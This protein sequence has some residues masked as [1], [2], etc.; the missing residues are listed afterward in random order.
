MSPLTRVDAFYILVTGHLLDFNAAYKLIQLA[1]LLRV[2]IPCPSKNLA[3]KKTIRRADV[4]SSGK[5]CP[6]VTA[7]ADA[8]SCNTPPKT[9]NVTWL[10]CVQVG[11]VQLSNECQYTARDIVPCTG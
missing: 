5:V 1:T 7:K 11:T 10:L 9:E 3:L 6:Y 8:K 4:D 2:E